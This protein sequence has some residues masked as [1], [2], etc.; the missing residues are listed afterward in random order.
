MRSPATSPRQPAPAGRPRRAPRS[1]PLD[2]IGPDRAHT[3]SLERDPPRLTAPPAAISV[4]A[5]AA[6][7][8]VAVISLSACGAEP[9]AVPPKR[10]NNELIIGEYERHKPDGETAIRFRADGSVRL[11]KTRALLD[12]EPPLA[13]GTWKLDGGKLTVTYDKGL[14][15]ERSGDQAGTYNVVISKIGIHFSK[16]ED[17]CERRSSID[18]QT[19]WRIK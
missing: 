2:G 11:A 4:S 13:T 5:V 6:L 1:G 18:G 3:H 12:T 8:L 10:P 17:S 15:T 14:C 19:W 9:H 16:V 7:A